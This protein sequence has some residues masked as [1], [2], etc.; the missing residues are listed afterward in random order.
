MSNRFST[1]RAAARVLAALTLV[2]LLT[3]PIAAQ[4]SAAAAPVLDDPTAEGVALI[5][6]YMSILGLPAD[7]KAAGLD[8][9]L[10]PG[11][12]VVRA[13]GDRQDR[14]EYLASPP[15]VETYAI[16]DARATQ[17]DDLLVVSYLFEAS[18]VLDGVEQ[19]T[20]APRLSVFRWSGGEWL[21]AAHANFG[22]IESPDT[23]ASGAD[24]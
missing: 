5:D 11:F 2:L 10:A 3:A 13:N 4:T 12:Q 21:L 24:G 6:G 8:G 7:D 22:A 17:D 9:L 15:T 18:E 14:A 20:T 1:A 23:E 19:T 16:S